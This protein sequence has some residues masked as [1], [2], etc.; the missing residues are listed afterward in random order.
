MR[1]GRNVFIISLLLSTFGLIAIFTASWQW[2]YL[3]LNNP[4]YFLEHQL[5]YLF[6]GI[7]LAFIIYLFSL[8]FLK[9][10]SIVFLI[11]STILLYSVFIKDIGKP[12]RGASRWIDLG[13]IQFQPAP[14]LRFSWILFLA[15]FLSRKR[16][17]L[18]NLHIIWILIF[19][20][21]FGIAFYYQP[22]MSMLILFSLATFTILFFSNFNLKRLIPIFLLALLVI[23]LLTKTASYR[24]ERIKS[25]SL[26]ENNFPIFSTYQQLHA[27]RMI[28]DG[29]I[30][31]KGW[32]RDFYKLFLPES[33]ND[34]IF[35]VILGEGGWIAGFI[36]ISLYFLLIYNIFLLAV[37]EKN[38][39]NYLLLTGIL[40]FWCWQILLNIF[41]SLGFLPVMGLPLPFISFGGSSLISNWMKIGIILK[42]SLDRR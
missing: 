29:G 23:F 36:L 35:P 37:E 9:K 42:I 32:G 26:E 24:E 5:I 18:S 30:I 8:D 19:L 41:M 16:R 34:F 39:F 31:G 20:G 40:S 14:F 12:I 21:V 13:I 27:M 15:S 17:D 10:I 22:N 7:A 6:L 25:F 1:K 38:I 28:R 3:Y 11:L 33:Y 4:Y 2:A